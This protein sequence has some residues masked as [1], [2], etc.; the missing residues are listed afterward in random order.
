MEQARAE[1]DVREREVA[2]QRAAERLRRGRRGY[3]ALAL[4][5][6]E[7]LTL[8]EVA[9]NLMGLRRRRFEAEDDYRPKV[10]TR[11]VQLFG[12]NWRWQDRIDAPQGHI[13]RGMCREAA[14]I[15]LGYPDRDSAGITGGTRYESWT[16]DVPRLW[17]TVYLRD[18]V[19][20]SWTEFNRR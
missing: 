14:L 10:R 11:A 8:D 1:R 6:L 20:E 5:D 13:R 2:E 3:V 19:V 4:E 7:E 12:K 15:A 18:G 16:F 9:I 17:L